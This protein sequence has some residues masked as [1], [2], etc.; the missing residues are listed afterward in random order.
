MNSKRE[1]K[2]ILVIDDDL[3]QLDYIDTMLNYEYEIYKAKSGEKALEYFHSG[4]I[5]DLIL[6][7]IVMPDMDGWEAFS[8]IRSISLFETVPIILITSLKGTIEEKRGR[9]MGAA[10]YIMKPYTKNEL[11]ERVQKVLG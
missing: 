9:T 5:P 6:L 11:L 10:D 2:V 1:K 8:K 3:I 7:D 4:F